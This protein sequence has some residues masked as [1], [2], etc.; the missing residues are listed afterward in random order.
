MKCCYERAAKLFRR[1]ARSE[2]HT[3][4]RNFTASISSIELE[5]IYLD[6]L[7]KVYEKTRNNNFAESKG[8]LVYLRGC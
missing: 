8:L 3:I 4:V 6:E 1:M 2:G 7:R 5:N